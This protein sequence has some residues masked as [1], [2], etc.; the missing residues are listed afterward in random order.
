MFELLDS[1]SELLRG[2]LAS[3]WLWLIVFAVSALDALLPF[4]P[5]ETTVVTVA[6]LLGPDLPRL[7]LLVATAAL[8][9]LAGDCLSHWI[10]RRA[11]PRMLARLQRGERGQARYEWAQTQVDRHNALLIV[12]AR[13]LPGGRV[14]SGLATGSM[15]VPWS[16]F[17]ALDV[18]GTCIWA[19]YSVCIGCVGGMAFADSPGKGLVL[20]FAIGLLL[21]GAIELVRRIRSR[22]AAR[23][24]SDGDPD[25]LRCPALGST[26]SRP[27]GH[28]AHVPEVDR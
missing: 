10:G 8:G 22:H 4:M 17:V 12:A 27:G 9:A 19:V 6:V 15:G 16:R 3:P 11:G 7:A 23:G 24:L 1:I 13:Y 5:S 18:L 28:R 2:T 25:P 14:A 26:G 21:V 20:S